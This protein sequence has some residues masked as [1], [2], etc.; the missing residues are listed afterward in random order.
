MKNLL[1][2]IKP[3]RVEPKP[4]VSGSFGRF[5]A[6]CPCLASARR[7]PLHRKS[8][9]N[10]SLTDAKQFSRS[11]GLLRQAKR[12]RESLMDFQGVF[13]SISEATPVKTD[14]GT[15]LLGFLYRTCVRRRVRVACLSGFLDVCQRA[16]K[17]FF[18]TL[19]RSRHFCRE[20]FFL[21]KRCSCVRITVS[22][23]LFS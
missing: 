5:S 2:K 13:R 12:R 17:Y 18:D 3:R 6:Y 1:D 14:L 19:K 21:T 11:V 4:S 23:I 9:Q 22:S 8:L 7:R 20:R 16:K 10:C 15:A